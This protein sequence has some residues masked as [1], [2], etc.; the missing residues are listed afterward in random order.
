MPRRS[1]GAELRNPKSLPS[2]GLVVVA[3]STPRF[4]EMLR[5]AAYRGFLFQS[6]DLARFWTGD[7]RVALMVRKFVR[8]GGCAIVASQ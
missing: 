3:A 1:T 7:L 8:I 5:G 2:S 4:H 6:L